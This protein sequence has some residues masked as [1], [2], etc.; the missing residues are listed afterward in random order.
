MVRENLIVCREKIARSAQRAGRSIDD[1][2]LVAVTKGVDAGRI[3]E[4]I[5]AGI[6][7]IGES[8]LQEALLKVDRIN[9]FSG[10]R[11]A[12]LCWHFL[13]HLQTNKVK[14]A[15]RLFDVI[16]SVDSLRLAETIERYAAQMS[17]V[18]EI[19]LEVNVSGEGS[20]YGLAPSEI[21]E[22]LKTIETW[23]HVR[24]TGLMTIAPWSDAPERARPVFRTLRELRD[25]L[26]SIP[27]LRSDIRH[28]SM[29]MTDD[30]EVAVE[31]GATLVRLGRAVF[32]ERA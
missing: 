9:R 32:G 19:M 5:A 15:V 11:G 12:A 26:G 25:T 28:L 30:F 31:E 8:R 17:K 1:A 10:Q 14:D 6:G 2:V 3:E 16:H 13:G 21:F 20:K 4:A 23:P 18:Q 22:V 7:H 29:G 27:N 24:V